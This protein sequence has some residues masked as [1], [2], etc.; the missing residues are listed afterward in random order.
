MLVENQLVE[1]KWYSSNKNWYESK[2]Y[3]FTKNGDSFLVNADELVLSSKQKVFVVCDICG[4]E[5]NMNYSSYINS[6]KNNGEYHCRECS[7]EIGAQKLIDKN[8]KKYFNLFLNWCKKNNY[9]PISTID[10]YINS[11]SDLYFMCNIHGKG[12]ISCSRIQGGQKSGG[13]CKGHTL[14]NVK[15]EDIGFVK[16]TVESKNNNILLNANEYINARKKNLR[17]ICGSCNKEFVASFASIISGNGMCFDC[18]RD[19][20][21]W[22]SYDSIIDNRYKKYYD[23]CNELGYYPL[24]T[25]DDFGSMNAKGYIQFLCPNHGE[26]SQLY[27]NF[28]NGGS[29]CKHCSDDFRAS[30][31][32][33]DSESI[34]SIIESKN[35]NKLVDINEYKNSI[36]PISIQCGS[37][38]KIFKQS[39]SNYQRAN[40][41]GKCQDCNE[42]S[43]SEYI[44]STI[45]DKYNIS[46]IR[47]YKFDDCRDKLPLPFDFYL[48]EYNLCIEFDGLQH[49]KPIWGENQFLTTK[50]HDAMKDN[51]CRWNNINMLRIPYWED[52]NLETI[53]KKHLRIEKD[54]INTERNAKQLKIK[55]IPNRKIA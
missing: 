54:E 2:G 4:K 24:M 49:Y 39:L 25:K 31:L 18:G 37:C 6:I 9:T 7:K 35:K 50:L 53:L 42:I 27:N 41:T 5:T 23:R 40:V 48:H 51:Y 26:V 33:Y 36:T 15:R 44:I 29:M 45:L 11:L 21:N 32:K 19:I 52:K 55:Y 38:G 22:S 1:V 28:V 13:C 43:I 10:D 12:K 16:D 20:H 34:L 14:S 17:I 47:Q 8:K 30:K 46:Y 3:K